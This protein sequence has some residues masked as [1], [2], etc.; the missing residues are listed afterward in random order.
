MAWNA[1]TTAEIASGKPVCGPTG[2]GTKVRDCLNWLYGVIG[3]ASVIGIPNGSFEIDSDSD[4]VPDSWTK[5]LYAGGTGGFYT[6]SPAHGATAWSFTHP[7]G[8]SNGGGYLDSDYLEVAELE[9]YWL[10]FIH[11]ATAA[12]MRNR[13]EIRYYDKA[14]AELGAGSPAYLY[15]SVTNPTTATRFS[16]N[17]TP[18]ATTRYIK[19]RLV[20][21]FTD[22]DVAGTAY[23]DN[24]QFG[25]SISQ[26]KLKTSQGEVSTTTSG[27]NYLLPGGEYGFYPRIKNAAGGTVAA[28]IAVA[29]NITVYSTVITLRGDDAHDV[30]AQQRYV[31]SSGEVHWIFFLRDKLTKKVIASYQAPDHPCF[32]NG[33]DPETAAHPFLSYKKETQEIICVTMT[34]EEAKKL[35][36]SGRAAG[37]DFLQY[38]NEDHEI[39]EDAEAQWPSIPVSVGLRDD[40]GVEGTVEK[41][42]ISQP[43]YILAR[44]LKKS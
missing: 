20:G 29:E 27:A 22:T 9:N 2:F 32:G 36:E 21:G 44:S 41:L 23:F 5:S 17:F 39:D 31:T 10:S 28:S 7:G 35:K 1:I 40:Y 11:W 4:G 19:F 16:Y 8:A 24:I 38:L 30:Y 13:V 33:G 6:T 25:T 26:L 15:N 43:D 34:P 18:L 3:S 12:G 37:K 14:K 42:V